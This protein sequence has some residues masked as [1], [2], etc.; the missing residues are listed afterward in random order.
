MA[1]QRAVDDS[2]G[3]ESMSLSNQARLIRQDVVKMAARAGVSHV[4]SALSIVDILTS[5]YFDVMDRDRD[6]FVLSKA[7]ASAALYATLAA[8]G[9]LPRESLSSYCMHGGRLPGHLGKSIPGVPH[10]AGS[11]GHGLSFAVGMA[12]V[13]FGRVFVLCGDGEMN[14]G[15]NY[16]ALMFA[17]HRKLSNL[18]LIVD[19]NQIQSFGRTEDVLAP[20]NI[21]ERLEGFGW[22]TVEIDGHDHEQISTLKERNSAPL[23]VI[24]HTVKGKGVSFM[25]N[26]LEW[27]YKSPLPAELEQALKE[28]A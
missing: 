19:T 22:L 3:E 26:N 13:Q 25:E 14:E 4:G 28:L 11:L 24:A 20:R 23:A 15:S 6:Q 9:I 27:H 17:A 8:R 10:V 2:V 18:T 16:E 5:L 1:K 12:V 21:R 7:H